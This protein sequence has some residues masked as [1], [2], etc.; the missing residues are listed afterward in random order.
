MMPLES[1]QRESPQRAK[2]Q[3]QPRTWEE[4]LQISRQSPSIQT[5]G[6]TGRMAS[7]LQQAG[8]KM[9]PLVQRQKRE[10]SPIPGLAMAP[11]GQT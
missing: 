2:T 8:R 4:T 10:H 6:Q 5:P 3:R 11:L 9:N 1:P 7:P